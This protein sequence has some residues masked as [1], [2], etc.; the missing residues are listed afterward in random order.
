MVEY[1]VVPIKEQILPT[2]C[3]FLPKNKN[4]IYFE[5]VLQNINDIFH[6]RLEYNTYKEREKDIKIIKKSISRKILQRKI[7]FYYGKENRFFFSEIERYMTMKIYIDYD[8]YQKE[9]RRYYSTLYLLLPTDLVY[10]V[11]EYLLDHMLRIK[12]E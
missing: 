6:V 12:I 11:L 5:F 2:S 3:S 9:I 7:F 4:M 10:L 8:A 1:F